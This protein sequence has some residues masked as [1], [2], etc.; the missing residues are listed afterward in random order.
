[1][2]T[3]EIAKLA[4]YFTGYL[5]AAIAFYY[6][7]HFLVGS[8]KYSRMFGLAAIVIYAL[9]FSLTTIPF[10][11]EYDGS[12]LYVIMKIIFGIYCLS[13]LFYNYKNK[14]QSS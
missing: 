7:S 14:R 13:I 8:R 1:M 3:Y 2:N 10:R 12:Y 11:K 9:V 5:M 6:A 4:I